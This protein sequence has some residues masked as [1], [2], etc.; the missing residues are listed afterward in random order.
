MN[1]F[2]EIIVDMTNLFNDAIPLEKEKLHAA[3]SKQI[4]FVEDCMKKEQALLLKIR[5]L[6][7]KR[8]ETLKELGYENKTFKQIINTKTGEEEK[9]LSMLFDNFQRAVNEFSS[10]NKEALKLIKLNMHDLNRI[11]N[12][13][14]AVQ[15]GNMTDQ[16]I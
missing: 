14:Q 9:R 4:T 2:E 1:R 12:E 15:S 6:E 8:I 5:G 10:I 3:A 11:I 7:Q 13:K 16:R